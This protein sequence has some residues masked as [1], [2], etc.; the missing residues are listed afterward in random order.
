[1]AN[2]L[3]TVKKSADPWKLTAEREEKRALLPM[4]CFFFLVAFTSYLFTWKEDQ[5][6]VFSRV[7][8]SWLLIGTPS[9]S[10]I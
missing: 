3:K 2:R 9:D 4:L 6:K 7:F 5:D 8:P 1:M 10:I